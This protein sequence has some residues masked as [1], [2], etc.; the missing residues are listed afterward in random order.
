MSLERLDGTFGNIA[1]VHIRWD[2]LVSAFPILSDN[3]VVL[4]TGFIVKNLVI[5]CMAACLEALHDSVV[6]GNAVP[7][8]MGLE[9]LDENDIGIAVVC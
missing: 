7:V 2:K 9:G 1:A 5:Y 8:V 3:T 6:S 4:C